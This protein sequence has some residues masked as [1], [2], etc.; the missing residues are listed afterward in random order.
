VKQVV[1]SS[2]QDANQDCQAGVKVCLFDE[3]Q[4]RAKGE[5]KVAVA[6]NKLGLHLLLQAQECL[7][8]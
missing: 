2:F 7:E 4:Q 3:P 5:E 6:H 8:E 1:H